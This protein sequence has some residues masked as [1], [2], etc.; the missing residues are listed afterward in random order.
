MALYGLPS[1][2]LP[3]PAYTPAISWGLA[4]SAVVVAIRPMSINNANVIRPVRSIS[5]ASVM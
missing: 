3:S 5:S 4:G 1:P 2:L